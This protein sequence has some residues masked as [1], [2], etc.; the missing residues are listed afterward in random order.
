MPT[1]KTTTLPDPKPPNAAPSSTTSIMPASPAESSSIDGSPPP[2]PTKSDS[3]NSST[4]TS[5]TECDPTTKDSSIY[6]TAFPGLPPS[7]PSSHAHILSLP[8]LS[9]IAILEVNL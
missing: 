1:S 4:S 6:T 5:P 7:N 3:V 9:K 8:T 2:S